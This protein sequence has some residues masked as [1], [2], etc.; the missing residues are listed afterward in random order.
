MG[1]KVYENCIADYC[2]N[3]LIGDATVGV[4]VLPFLIEILSSQVQQLEA[5]KVMHSYREVEKST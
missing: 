1:P 3:F 4:L 5:V 2:L